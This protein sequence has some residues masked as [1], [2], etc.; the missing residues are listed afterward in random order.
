M[1]KKG[2]VL[3]NLLLALSIILFL[4]VFIVTI[5]NSEKEH[6]KI[7]DFLPVFLMIVG[8]SV[9][10]LTPSTKSSYQLFIGLGFIFIGGFSFLLMRSIIGGTL[11]QLWPVIGIGNGVILLI[12]GLYKYRKISFG[13]VIPSIAMIV[14]SA[15]FLLFSLKIVSISFKEFIIV[16]GPLLLVMLCVLLFVVYI[17]KRNSKSSEEPDQFQDDELIPE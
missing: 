12:A 5:F 15:W 17:F 9:A 2:Y 14:L 6:A 7:L 11:L 1:N 10:L 4:V 13:Y 16:F 3:L 8:L